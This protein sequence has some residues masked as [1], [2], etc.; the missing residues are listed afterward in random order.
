MHEFDNIPFKGY[1]GRK[2]H[3]SSVHAVSYFTY[4]ETTCILNIAKNF[5]SSYLFAKE[6]WPLNQG[7]K[8]DEKKVEN[9]VKLSL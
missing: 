5:A 9:L 8:T 4:F 3:M 2:N 1:Q 6:L 7:R